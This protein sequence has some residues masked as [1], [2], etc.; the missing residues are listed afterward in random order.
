LADP[1]LGSGHADPQPHTISSKLVAGCGT[2]T[3]V[4]REYIW[5]LV[6]TVEC[7]QRRG[8]VAGHQL[9]RGVDLFQGSIRGM[10]DSATSRTSHGWGGVSYGAPGRTLA[11][12]SA[13]L[14]SNVC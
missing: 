3:G 11:P 9:G 7:R 8:M 5:I 2:A 14:K 4:N 12:A 6:R 10:R 13:S 1:G